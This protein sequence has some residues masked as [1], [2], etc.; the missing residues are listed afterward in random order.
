MKRLFPLLLL[1]LSA[2]SAAD[3]S[4]LGQPK[5]AEP[6]FV[7]TGVGTT[8]DSTSYAIQDHSDQSNAWVK[9]G[10][11]LAGYKVSYDEN[12]GELVLSNA[13]DVLHLALLR[14]PI[15]AAPDKEDKVAQDQI[16]DLEGRL[17]KAQ[18]E[19]NMLR[20][21][22]AQV[23]DE[24]LTSSGLY[25]V[26]PGDTGAKIAKNFGL[27]VNELSS[28]NPQQN[29]TRLRAGDVLYTPMAAPKK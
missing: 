22:L 7:W 25:R 10:D 24:A 29:F 13:K 4:P 28:M 15:E 14:K 21:K 19:I 18:N 8:G 17:E 5:S 11:E 26:K 20:A 2:A 6:R 23:P 16:K 9:A 1:S 27:P 3:P 12:K